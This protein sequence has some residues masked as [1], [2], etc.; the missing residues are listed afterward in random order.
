MLAMAKKTT[1]KSVK[2]AGKKEIKPVKIPVLTTTKIKTELK[3]TNPEIEEKIKQDVAAQF[4]KTAQKPERD[5]GTEKTLNMIYGGVAIL[6]VLGVLI[7]LLALNIGVSKENEQNPLKNLVGTN[8]SENTSF[9]S[10]KITTGSLPALG[11]QNA[12]ITVILFGDY[13]CP[14]YNKFYSNV[15]TKIK[16]DY[17]NTEKVKMYFRDLP[18]PSLHDKAETMALVARCANEQGKF[19]EMHDKLSNAYGEWSILPVSSAAEK[20]KGYGTQLRLD[21]KQFN[22]CLDTKKYENDM[23]TDYNY[24]V[25]K[26]GSPATPRTFI[27]LPKNKTNPDTLRSLSASYQDIIVVGQD[28]NNYVVGVTGMLPYDIFKLIF[29]AAGA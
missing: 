11:S 5:E 24:Y 12:E 21:G 27:L 18:I 14:V 26:F 10:L 22:T 29:S 4:A 1:K 6:A 3:P 2:S 17:V 8:F 7:A 20:A 23:K 16:N 9:G 13:Q 25:G 28:G 19:C 15:E